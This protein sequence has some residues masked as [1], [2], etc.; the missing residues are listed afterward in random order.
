[1]LSQIPYTCH[2]I[3][4][5]EYR[6]PVM[7]INS[8]LILLA[9]SNL[10]YLL[11]KR[12]HSKQVFT[13][14][15]LDISTALLL[16][17]H[18]CITLLSIPIPTNEND[19]SQSDLDCSHCVSFFFPQPHQQCKFTHWV[20]GKITPAVEKKVQTTTNSLHSYVWYCPLVDTMCQIMCQIQNRIEIFHI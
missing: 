15:L 8:L 19:Q 5:I 17:Y 11:M 13:F 18:I 1:M 7:Y 4:Q 3:M 9:M 12:A 16:S 6:T 20:S 14:S 10:L 2:F